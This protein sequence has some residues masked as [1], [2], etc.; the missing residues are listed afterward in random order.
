MYT[1]IILF[2][3]FPFPFSF[4]FFYIYCKTVVK[5]AWFNQ[6]NY[7]DN[8]KLQVKFRNTISSDLTLYT[9]INRSKVGQT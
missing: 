7:L 5:L 1:T 6:T 2:F 9:M 8:G 3:P 4:L